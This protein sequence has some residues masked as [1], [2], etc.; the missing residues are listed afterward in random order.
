MRKKEK[1]CLSN[2]IC[3]WPQKTW[4]PAN[5]APGQLPLANLYITNQMRPPNW[6]TDTVLPGHTYCQRSDPSCPAHKF[7]NPQ[8]DF[9]ARSRGSRVEN[10]GAFLPCCDYTSNQTRHT[11]DNTGSPL[12]N[13]WVYKAALTPF[14]KWRPPAWINARWSLV[15]FLQWILWWH[16]KWPREQDRDGRDIT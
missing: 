15:G 1:R 13:I 5:L 11:S 2:Q 9:A 6:T 12:T 10:T 16:P 14:F 3:R 7:L 4:E 8:H